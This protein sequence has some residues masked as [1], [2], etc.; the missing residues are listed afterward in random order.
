[1]QRA[2][3]AGLRPHS[4]WLLPAVALGGIAMALDGLRTGG[5]RLDALHPGAV[6]PSGWLAWAG[7]WLA[8]GWGIAAVV[9]VVL[10]L[11]SRRL[12][13]ISMLDRT[14]L[15][16]A[17]ATPDTLVRG[18]VGLLLLLGLGVALHGVLAGAARSVDA[19]EAGLGGL[20][21]GWAVRGC[22]VVAGVLVLAAVVD[23]L[24]DRR[25]RLARLFMSREQQREQ[26]RASGG[27]A[28]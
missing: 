14:R 22:A 9:V 24:V 11:L 20:W 5:A 2:W 1:M 28:R 12:G 15:R 21:L 10:G 18:V 8:L 6:E 16:A 7:G 23:L 13:V 3:R 25:D 27:A 26:A 4:A 17:A 19:S